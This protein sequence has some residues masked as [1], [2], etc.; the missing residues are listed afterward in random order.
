M[1]GSSTWLITGTKASA[2]NAALRS[3]SRMTVF[4]AGRLMKPM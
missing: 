3:G 4:S 1:P 2:L